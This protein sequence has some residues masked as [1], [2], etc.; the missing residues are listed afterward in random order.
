MKHLALAI[1]IL[2]SCII[3]LAA[4]PPKRPK[5]N[6]LISVR[7]RVSDLQKSREFYQQ[8][9]QIGGVRQQCFGPH[10]LCLD[11]NSMQRIELVQRDTSSSSNLVEQIGFQTE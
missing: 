8:T 2:T 10:T 9:F 7:F 6:A 1:A 11:V 5:I 4:P 3:S